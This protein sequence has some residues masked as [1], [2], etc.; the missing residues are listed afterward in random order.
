MSIVTEQCLSKIM[1]SCATALW[2]GALNSAMGEFGLTTPRRQAM[3]LAQVAH[4]SGQCRRLAENLNYSA[5]R[6]LAVFPS[7]FDPAMA[8]KYARQPKEIA[9][10][11][12]AGRLG[13]GDRSSGD[14]WRFRGRGLIQITGRLNYQ[15]C[16]QSLGT[17]LLLFPDLLAKDSLMAARSAAWFFA[18]HANCIRHADAQDLRA[19]TL[20]INGGLRGWDDREHFYRCACAALGVGP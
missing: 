15:S 4:E 13:N 18:L 19:C 9:N 1:P 10:I 7:R 11:A 8:R 16:G 5:D 3:F 12:Y 14:G 2:I 17:D 20:R 6:L